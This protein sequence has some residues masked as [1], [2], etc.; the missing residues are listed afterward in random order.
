MRASCSS[1]TMTITRLHGVTSQNT[2]V[3]Q[4]INSAM[5]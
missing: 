3:I 4:Y 2:A 1:K 5:N